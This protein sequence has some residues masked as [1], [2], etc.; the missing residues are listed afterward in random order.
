MQWSDSTELDAQLLSEYQQLI[1]DDPGAVYR[2]RRAGHFTASALMVDPRRGQVLLLMHPKVG[3]WLQF[4]GH[5]EPTDSSFAGAALRE[6]REESGYIDVEVLAAPA[7]LDRHAV[8]CAGEQSVHWDVQY[9]AIVDRD[10]QCTPTEDL[11]VQWWDLARV[12]QSLPDPDTS[13]LRLI[14]A[15]QSL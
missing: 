10:S 3:R 2:D 4:G 1:L 12:S 7:A 11:Q 6:C 9:L 5:I 15:A 8:P 13:V 14:A